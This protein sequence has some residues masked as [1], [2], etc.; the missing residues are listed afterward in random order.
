[1][2]G[3]GLGRKGAKVRWGTARRIVV[4]W[5]LTLPAAAVVGALAAAVAHLGAAGI[6]IDAV[7]GVLVIALMFWI[8]RRNEVS[9]HNAI[10]DLDH[11]GEVVKIKRKKKK[12]KN[13]QQ[14]PQ[15][16][17]EPEVSE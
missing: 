14:E 9:H 12:K 8:S 4:G 1:V 3:S 6:I 17:P 7:A 5:L 10:S 11:V 2:I 15:P 16:Q 13:R